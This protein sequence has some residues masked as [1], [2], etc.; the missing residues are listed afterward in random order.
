MSS[1][2]LPQGFSIFQPTLGAQ[3]QFYPAVGT[4]ELDAL[5]HAHLIG[6]AASQEKRATL[7][8][9]FLE[10][11]Q[12][13]GQSFKFY[14]VHAAASPATSASSSFNTSP[15]TAS[16]DWSQNS[17]TASVSSRSSQHRVSKPTSPASRMRA[18]DFS[19]LPGMKIMTKDGLDVT[20]SASRGSKTKEQR[21]HA[22]LMR[23]IKACDSCKKKKIRCDPSHKKRAAATPA[24]PTA[25][26]KLT[27][28][29]RTSSPSA[30]S[31]STSP[32]QSVSPPLMMEEFGSFS[33]SP[34]DMDATFSFDALDTFE[35]ALGA[36]TDPWDEFVQ[37]P[38]MGQAEDYDFFADPDSFLS[39]QSSDADMSA[40]RI[41]IPA[42]SPRSGA[43]PGR[44][45][46]AGRTE[47]HTE[48]LAG[49]ALPASVSAHMPYEDSQDWGGDYSDFNLYSPGSSFSEDERMLD[50]GSST[51]G[52]STQSIPSPIDSPRRPPNAGSPA[53]GADGANTGDA[54]DQSP[55]TRAEETDPSDRTNV[56]DATAGGIAGALSV[57]SRSDVVMRTNEQGQ[58]IICC[59]PGTVV[60]NS[61]GQGSTGAGLT[62]VS[63]TPPPTCIANPQRLT[64]WKVSTVHDSS[65]SS[66]YIPRELSV[67]P[68]FPA[69]RPTST[70]PMKELAVASVSAGTGNV[71]A[72][73]VA[74]WLDHGADGQTPQ[75][76]APIA[77]ST[78]SSPVQLV[79]TVDNSQPSRFVHRNTDAV[80]PRPLVGLA[81]GS[82]LGAAA[83]NDGL[84]VS[85]GLATGLAS[86]HTSA[87]G[88]ASASAS[89][90]AIGLDTLASTI[91]VGVASGLATGSANSSPACGIS[92]LPSSLTSSPINVLGG[93]VS[94]ESGSRSSRSVAQD[95]DSGVFTGTTLD[96]SASALPDGGHGSPFDT[97]RSASDVSTSTSS[98]LGN[99]SSK[100]DDTQ[101]VGSDVTDMPFVDHSSS[102]AS[103]S[104]ASVSSIDESSTSS[105]VASSTGRPGL[106]SESA[107][108]A[109]QT[110]ASTISQRDTTGVGRSLQSRDAQDSVTTTDLVA[111][112]QT[113]LTSTLI[114]AAYTQS[115]VSSPTQSIRSIACRE[116]APRA[117]HVL[118]PVARVPVI[119]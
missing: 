15:A 3:L 79:E 65:N 73:S 33:A 22:H 44:G 78:Q 57:L 4:Q 88:I 102:D 21:D 90:L 74:T 92:S 108:G 55:F 118:A 100:S 27:K 1:S 47:S 25:T 117:R 64:F 39:S 68:A 59:P 107:F 86:A 52:L 42:S 54:A 116:Y 62:N 87:T 37:Y 35:P 114:A 18:A 83:N 29:P 89:G 109:S 9:D 95:T 75:L 48:L 43:P 115:M 13:T 7:A 16:W 26:A 101:R 70:N 36:P 71:N 2:T 69:H 51:S 72:S 11:A 41:S 61:S 103:E 49:A 58:L 53:F 96:A 31:Q 112:M 14:P 94:D 6:P 5:I 67:R 93:Y 34:F 24:A 12:R 50:I 10:H 56:R 80:Q 63:P 105:S 81:V 77:A 111:M 20:N 19:G 82:P 45:P 17:R 84:A 113:V 32:P 99:K 60:I 46:D 98:D 106:D 38:P 97:V 30:A 23:I 119:C 8:L 40:A 66:S 91:S 28:K 110:A 85:T 104:F 76:A